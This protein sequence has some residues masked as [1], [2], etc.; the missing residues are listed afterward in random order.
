MWPSHAPECWKQ[1]QDTFTNVHVIHLQ[2]LTTKI[3]VFIL[4]QEKQFHTVLH[5][6]H[7]GSATILIVQQS[8][9][10]PFSAVITFKFNQWFFSLN[11]EEAFASWFW[12]KL[13]LKIKLLIWEVKKQTCLSSHFWGNCMILNKILISKEAFYRSLVI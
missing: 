9:Q 4:Y 12:E 7:F 5:P 6:K 1:K 11:W 2:I 8:S 13:S 10:V 3:Y